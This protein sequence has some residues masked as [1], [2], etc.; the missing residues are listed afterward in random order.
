MASAKFKHPRGFPFS[1]GFSLSKSMGCLSNWDFAGRPAPSFLAET[2]TNFGPWKHRTSYTL[3]QLMVS[4]RRCME[5]LCG[6]SAFQ[7]INFMVPWCSMV[8]SWLGSHGFYDPA[9]P[10]SRPEK[11]HDYSHKSGSHPVV[12]E[13][14]CQYGFVKIEDAPKTKHRKEKNDRKNMIEGNIWKYGVQSWNFILAIQIGSAP[15]ERNCQPPSHWLSGTQW[16]CNAI[17]HNAIPHVSHAS[18][19]PE[20]TFQLMEIW[21][22]TAMYSSKP[23]ELQRMLNFKHVW[24]QRIASSKIISAQF[25]VKK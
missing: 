16:H 15:N 2:P 23:N 21:K 3:V 13:R 4:S 8:I 25:S 14:R 9:I 11:K 12:H 19:N 7:M 22:S 17:H 20:G 24:S 1:H 18:E 10:I 6:I 5:F